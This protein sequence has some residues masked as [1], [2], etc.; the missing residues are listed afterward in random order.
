MILFAFH[1]ENIGNPSLFDSMQRFLNL[2]QFSSTTLIVYSF[3]CAF[4]F[5]TQWLCIAKDYKLRLTIVEVRTKQ[6]EIQEVFFRLTRV[7]QAIDPS[8][9]SAL[10]CDELSSNYSSQLTIDDAKMYTRDRIELNFLVF[11]VGLSYK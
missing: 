6:I 2:L 4:A 3:S 11:Y 5:C 1:Y 10:N 7:R 8:A 9:V